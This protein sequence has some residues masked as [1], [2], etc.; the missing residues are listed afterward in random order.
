MWIVFTLHV[1]YAEVYCYVLLN[2]LLFL[3]EGTNDFCFC[4][5]YTYL[6]YSKLYE[7]LPVCI[8]GS[9]CYVLWNVVTFTAVCMYIY[10]YICVKAG[11]DVVLYRDLLIVY[12]AHIIGKNF[13]GLAFWGESFMNHQKQLVPINFNAIA[14][15]IILH[16]FY[17][18]YT[19]YY[20]YYHQLV[21]V[22][23]FLLKIIMYLSKS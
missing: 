18:A 13:H 5:K 12:G 22:L 3:D 10:V 20:C 17:T 16:I 23:L 21:K 9:Y 1:Y 6:F 15:V 19:T 2:H 7:T 8:W 4:F 14:T 11:V